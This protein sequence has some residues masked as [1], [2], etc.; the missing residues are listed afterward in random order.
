MA[1]NAAPTHRSTS[2][3]SNWVTTMTDYGHELTFGVMIGPLHD[4]R[5]VVRLA[6]ITEE[7]GLN[8][9]SLPDHPYWPERLDTFTLLT[10]IASRTNKVRVV[11]NLA[12]LPLRPP[13]MLARAA[14]TLSSLSAGR[15]DL[16]I[17]AGAQQMWDAIVAEGGPRRSA[18]ESIDA[19]A[20]AVHII[21]TLWTPGPDLHFKGRHYRFDGTTRGPVPAHKIGIWL[22]AYQQR[23][24]RLVGATADG[25]VS[26][27]LFLGPERIG[28]ANKVIDAAALGAGRAPGAVR[29]VYNIAGDFSA[30][31]AEF[32]HGPPAAWVEQLTELALSEG[33]GTYLLFDCE[34]GDVIRRFA[35]EVAP[36]VRQAVTAER[37]R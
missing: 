11:S 37:A 36:A 13:A 6:E 25:W 3:G 22:G 1:S 33:I 21:R 12:N 18:G 30:T 26:T 8:V 7:V 24:L 23:L 32:L 9:V 19:L 2:A 15:F 35:G 16:G 28:N 5:D 29:R 20:E 31:G 17:G 34:S 10:A 4:G 14:A 27:S